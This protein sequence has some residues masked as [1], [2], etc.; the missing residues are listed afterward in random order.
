MQRLTACHLFH[1]CCEQTTTLSAENNT[2]VESNCASPAARRRRAAVAAKVV[3]PKRKRYFL[4][5]SKCRMCI[6]VLTSW[7]CT[8][9]RTIVKGWLSSGGLRSFVEYLK[10]QA[11]SAVQT[12]A[13]PYQSSAEMHKTVRSRSRST[14]DTATER[15]S[16]FSSEN[17]SSTVQPAASGGEPA[18]GRQKDWFAPPLPS[19]PRRGPGGI[20]PRIRCSDGPLSSLIQP[21][22]RGESLGSPALIAPQP[23]YNSKSTGN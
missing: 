6:F 13:I 16:A 12:R 3:W 4:F 23:R 10:T 14:F 17:M 20:L 8:F 7:L 19:S 9:R 18:R 15:K 21:N 2:S 1:R 11:Q 22:R 5:P